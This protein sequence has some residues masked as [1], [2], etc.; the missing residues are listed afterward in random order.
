[1]SMAF[2]KER[3]KSKNLLDYYDFLDTFSSSISLRYF[4]FAAL[5]RGREELDIRENII[6]IKEMVRLTSVYHLYLFFCNDATDFEYSFFQVWESISTLMVDATWV[7]TKT[8]DYMDKAYRPLLMER[9]CT[10]VSGPRAS[11]SMD[12][13]ILNQS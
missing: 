1:M 3:G 5:K 2:A 8:I 6:V 13:N 9:F 12:K 4:C 7:N 10:K 11:S